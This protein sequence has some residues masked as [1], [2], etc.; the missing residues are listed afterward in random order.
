MITDAEDTVSFLNR[1]LANPGA[2]ERT[3]AMRNGRLIY[4]E[5]TRRRKSFL[6][7]PVSAVASERLLDE[8]RACLRDLRN[9]LASG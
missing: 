6:L 3:R 5:L 7:T 1:A 9:S 4:K 2:E 8:I